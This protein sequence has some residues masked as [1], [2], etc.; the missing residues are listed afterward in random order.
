MYK[1][2]VLAYGRQKYTLGCQNTLCQPKKYTLAAV[3]VGRSACYKYDPT[4][5]KRPKVGKQK[6]LVRCKLSFYV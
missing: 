2:S 5:H 6:F 1:T 4:A 3:R